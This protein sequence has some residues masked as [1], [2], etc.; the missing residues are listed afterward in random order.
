[1]KRSRF[2]EKNRPDLPF[3][4]GI[5][6]FWALFHFRVL[7]WHQT[8]VF[9]DCSRFFYPLWKWG[10]GVIHGGLLPLWNPDAGM[11]TPY[12]ADPEMA[13]WYP[14]KILLYQWLN[15]TGAFTWLTLLHHLWLLGGFWFWSKGRGFSRPASFLGCL[16]FGFSANAVSL[17]WAP[18]M[19]FTCSWIP[20]V[21]GSAERLRQNRKGAWWG[22]SLSAALQMTAG[23]PVMAYLTWLA[24]AL[25]WLFRSGWEEQGRIAPAQWWKGAGALGVAALFAAAWALPFW[26]MTAF[27]NAHRRL[28]MADAMGPANLATWFNPFYLGHPL[29]SHPEA[30]FFVSVYFIGLPIVVLAFWGLGRGRGKASL[31]LGA[32]LLVLS[33]G[34]KAAVGGWLKAFCPGYRWVARS[35]YWIPLVLFV[36]V[37]AALAGAE[38]LMNPEESRGANPFSLWLALSLGVFGMALLGGVPWELPSFWA[39]LLLLVLAGWKKVRTAWR[40]A[41]CLASLVLSLGPVVR[42]FHF[43]LDRSYYDERPALCGRLTAAGRIYQAPDFVDQYHVVSGN[44]VPDVYRRL[45]DLLIPDWPLAYGLEEVAYS[46]PIFLKEELHW[47]YAPLEVGPPVRR[48]ILDY[49]NVRYVLGPVKEGPGPAPSFWENPEP[50]PKWFSVEKAEVSG[51]WKADEERYGAPTFDFSKDCLVAD[52]LK[53]GLYV[54]RKVWETSRTPNAVDLQAVGKGKALLVSSE[55]AYPGWWGG[56]KGCWRPLEAVNHDF[57]GLVLGPGETQAEV[58]YRPASFRLGCFLSLLAV[59]F[60]SGFGLDFLVGSRKRK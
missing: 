51:S 16:A 43:T 56:V 36:T 13:V 20:W 39:A 9:L 6:I 2:F 50:Q 48:K 46:N 42:S 8:F 47:Y 7:F 40:W 44:S 45:K 26:E 59:V 41:F 31:P 58:V 30:P 24:L 10:S 12:L 32:T 60:W 15:P 22:L 1:M 5:G 57:R 34:E 4:L 21:F 18:S 28:D 19:F 49:L 25:E 52:A 23:Y 11:G 55:W 33:L 27:S 38:R 35:G 3:L 17:T 37:G 29:Y 53:Q 54:R 14:P